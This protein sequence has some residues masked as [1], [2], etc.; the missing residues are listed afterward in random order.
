MPPREII[1]N[2]IGIQQGIICNKAT[3]KEPEMLLP[4]VSSR[5]EP[6]GLTWEGEEAAVDRAGDGLELH[7]VHGLADVH[8]A[9]H[10]AQRAPH[11]LRH[12]LHRE[13]LQQLVEDG[14]ERVQQGGLRTQEGAQHLQ[15]LTCSSVQWGGNS[16]NNECRVCTKLLRTVLWLVLMVCE[17]RGNESHVGHRNQVLLQ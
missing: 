17:L 6:Q 3:A 1:T 8:R 2:I 5:P 10:A 12:L 9:G 16:R 7:H 11:E 14:G 4:S 13:H 15:F